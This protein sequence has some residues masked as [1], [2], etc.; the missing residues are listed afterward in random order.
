M[1]LESGT[2]LGPYEI[3]API[4]AGGMGEVYR[5]R[6]TRLDRLV[7][8]KVL[9]TET[10]SSQALERFEREAKAI[11]ALNHPG[12]CSIY[13][14]GTSPVPFLVMELLDGQTLHERLM[15]GPVDVPALV[16]LGLALADALAAAHGRGIVHRD[17]KPANIFLTAHGPKILDFGLARITETASLSDADATAQ[18]TLSAHSPL[19]DAGVA[20]G[21]VAY[22]SPEQLRG[23]ALDVRTDLF[24]LGLVLYEMATGRRAFS[25]TTSA[26]TSAAILHEQPVAP[27][28]LRPDLPPRLEQAVLTLLEKDR[29]LR[30]QTA[31]E[32]RAELTRLK[33]AL[34]G[35]RPSDAAALT[36]S[37]A[38]PVASSTSATGT[39]TLPPP[40]SSDAQLVAGLVRRH[41]GAFLGAVAVVLLVIVGAVYLTQRGETGPAFSAA[42]ARSIANLEV[43]QL[44]TSGTAGAPAIAPDGNY[45]AYV[46]QGTAGDSSLRVRQV[47]TGSNVEIVAVEP[48]VQLLGPTVTPDGTFVDY[49]KRRPG[50]PTE[51]WQVP[52]LGGSPRQLTAGVDSVVSFSPDGRQMAYVRRVGNGSQTEVVLAARDGGDD[53]VV[54]TRQSPETFVNTAGAGIDG[55]APA[56]SPDGTTLAVIGNRAG[57]SGHVV[58]I[59]LQTGDDRAVDFGPLVPAFGLVWLDEGTVLLSG[60]DRSSELA[61][62]WL[63]S[64]PQ[65]E[66]SRLTNDLNQYIGLSLTAD[67][68]QVVTTLSEVSLSIWTSDAT[69]AQWTQTVPTTPAKGPFG[70][71]VRWLG[72][73]LIYPS[74]ASGALALERWRAS[75][76]TTE[77][78]APGAGTPQVS[79]DGASI[80]FFDYD[81][82]ELWKMGADGRNKTLVGRGGPNERITPDGSQIT[83]VDAA[84]GTPTVRMRP[85]DRAGDTREITADRV[86]PGGAEVSPDGQ[87]IG[88]SAFDDQGRPALA[89]CDLATCA[90]R[91]TF[92]VAGAPQWTPDSLGLAYVDPV[93]RSDLWIQPLD[94]GAARQLA[95]FPA[96]GQQ[97]GDFAWSADGQRLAVLRYTV[98]N[99]IVLFRGLNQPAR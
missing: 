52:F 54:A 11:A 31:A 51:L 43:E 66:F 56:W 81:A 29:E 93:T 98:T 62:F 76:R 55:L 13:D 77:I 88:F 80:A 67:R 90:S 17:L 95:H 61:Q 7:A 39:M 38:V 10:T 6:D 24:S 94:G 96:G 5:A 99:N 33:R 20:V 37:V 34:G 25:G 19:T 53:R 89:V 23:E 92:S 45:V 26:V 57:F 47:T 16:D 3:L 74:T 75:T 9:P 44:T 65:G 1:P 27:R 78:L 40:S 71:G 72:D 64:Y 70:L 85:I 15:R 73:D 60:L 91:R 28:Q 4:G 86:R 79:Q 84:G 50:Q 97:I 48:G 87:W 14:V 82:G 41:R 36:P 68:N 46:E 32:L 22:M 42:T 30:T 69:A 18:P 35:S 59:N 8:V 58:F 63:L 49:L 2:R 83:F 12:I 21:T